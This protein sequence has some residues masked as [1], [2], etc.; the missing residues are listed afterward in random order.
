MRKK[1]RLKTGNPRHLPIPL[2]I[3]LGLLLAACSGDSGKFS[4]GNEYVESQTDLNI[5]D[6]LAVKLSTVLLDSVTTSGTGRLLVG[7]FEDGTFG[8]VSSDG[9]FRIG[10][11]DSL[12]YM[13]DDVYDSVRLAIR[14]DG[15]FYGDTTRNQRIIVHRLTEAIDF[16]DNGT[17]TS[18][19]GFDYDPDDIGSV[20]YTPTPAASDT[21][22]IRIDDATGEE[23]FDL[24]SKDSEILADDERFL[25]FFPGLA[26]VPD[27]ASG[28]AIIGFRADAEAEVGLIVYTSRQDVVRQTVKNTFHLQDPAL[29]FNRFVHDFSSTALNALNR[30]NEDLPSAA[31]ADAAFLQGGTGL[32]VRID[33]PSLSEL[34]LRDRGLIMKA[35]LSVAPLKN[36]DED[37]S[38]PPQLSLFEADGQNE[39]LDA[40]NAT[41]SASIQKDELYEEATA[42]VFDVTRYLKAELADSYVDPD[43]RLILMLPW[44]SMRSTFQ[45]ML[46]DARS[47]DTRLR[48]YYLSY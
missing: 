22:F 2:L 45:R 40:E 38:F 44:S 26:L 25:N 42:Y 32:A 37:Y 24:I 31:T 12:E 11:P 28:G 10:I 9:F 20:V 35:Q 6:T 16:G 3:L 29:Q 23:L 27:D 46:V 33:F 48:V 21:V 5:I 18:T 39:V 13:Q 34:L 19:D 4:L 14:Y 47:V 1:N 17:L 41:A 8:R 30:Q 15:T 7:T 43:K 36:S